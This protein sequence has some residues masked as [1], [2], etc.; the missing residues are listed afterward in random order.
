M[1]VRL[2]APTASWAA[3]P[4]DVLLSDRAGVQPCTE[5]RLE[6]KAVF[7]AVKHKGRK[8][9]LAMQRSRLCCFLEATAAEGH[10]YTLDIY[11]HRAVCACNGCAAMLLL[12]MHGSLLRLRSPW[13]PQVHRVMFGATVC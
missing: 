1:A 9:K 6:S 2:P 8:G 11:F 7:I 5:S 12:T 13:R 3:A 10:V 4:H